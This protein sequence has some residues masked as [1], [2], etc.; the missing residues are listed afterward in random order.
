MPEAVDVF[1]NRN[2]RRWDRNCLLS[3]V[4][5]P[6]IRKEEKES[7]EDFKKFWG[8]EER[9]ICRRNM[10]KPIRGKCSICTSRAACWTKHSPNQI[11]PIC[12]AAYPKEM[13]E[14]PFKHE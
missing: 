6:E 10:T 9:I 5:D 1:I 2:L 14:C 11:C 7:D 12:K 8:M 4:Q 3:E 13:Q